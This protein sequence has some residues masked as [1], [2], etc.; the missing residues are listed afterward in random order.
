MKRFFGRNTVRIRDCVD[1]C[2]ADC[3]NLGI[4]RTKTPGQ[5]AR[6]EERGPGTGG[7][8]GPVC[9]TSHTVA[10]KLRRFAA[11]TGRC[12]DSGGCRIRSACQPVPLGGVSTMDAITSDKIQHHRRCAH[13]RR[14]QR[15]AMVQGFGGPQA[16]THEYLTCTSFAARISTAI[17]TPLTGRAPPFQSDHIGR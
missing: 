13:G 8:R 4:I 11:R 3:S 15:N 14:P 2:V 17:R 10:A 5:L 9:I 12:A 7:N 6:V 16:K 1:A